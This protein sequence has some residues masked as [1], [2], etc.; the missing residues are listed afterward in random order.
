MAYATTD[1]E[2]KAADTA[3]IKKESLTDNSLSTAGIAYLIG[4][5]AMFAAGILKGNSIMGEAF[6]GAT[7]AIGGLGAARYGNPTAEKQ[8]QTLSARL[9]DYLKKQGTVIPKNPTT[10]LLTRKG[11]VIDNIEQF[12]YS[13]PSEVLNATYAIGATGLIRSGMNEGKW[14]RT[15]SGILVAAGALT[16][17]LIPEKK[18]DPESPP[19]GMLG[20]AMS[21][22]QE[23][24]LRL[25]SAF[26]WLNNVFLV[27][28]AYNE[29]GSNKA[30]SVCKFI[31]AG[32]YIF[33]NAMLSMS[34]KGHSDNRKEGM[35]ATAKLA[36]A[37]ASVI[38]AQP[39]QV[40]E[41][42]IEQVSGFLAS[43]P[44]TQMKAEDI[45][46]LL[47]EK[48]KSVGKTAPESPATGD[49]NWQAKLQNQ[50]A[51][52]ISPTL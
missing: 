45:S 1:N 20:K 30:S 17:L 15:T 42:L 4:D 27:K 11:G 28:D 47:H 29:W 8:L 5:A 13:H 43:Q 25:S 7:W 52:A 37:A 12:L 41:A 22:I 50:P 48:L 36:D 9:G 26:Y 49:T 24:P 16:G 21:W 33:A 6:T 31:T 38:A 2:K 39:Q 32:S 23:K 10:E 34:S 46:K 3:E 44:E 35:E 19:Q 40:Q 14:E 51:A 18:P